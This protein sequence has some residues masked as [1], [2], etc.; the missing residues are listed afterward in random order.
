MS[1]KNKK[2]RKLEDENRQFQ[3]SWEEDYFFIQVKNNAICLLCRDT[4]T[5]KS[6]NLRRHYEKHEELTKLSA[7]ERKAKFE[8]LKANLRSQQNVFHKQNQE[9]TDIVSTSFKISQIIAKKMKPFSD[10]EYIKECLIAAA[11]EICPDKV[12]S[13]KQISLSHQTVARRIDDISSEISLNLDMNTK[14]FV[15]F[16]L[17]LDETTDIKDTSQ[18]AIFIR[19][20]DNQMNITEELL[21]LV[22]LKDTTTGQDIKDAVLKCMEYRKLDLKKLIGITTDGAPSMIGKNEGAITLIRNHIESLGENSKFLDLFICHCFLHIENLCAQTLNMTHVMPVVINVINT[23]K[24]N[25]LKHR[26]F[27][28][29]IQELESEYCDLI[30][31]AK[32]RWLS[33]GKCLTRFWNLREEIRIFM[34]ENG[35]DVPQLYDEKWLLDLCFLIDITTK[36]NE[37]NQK[38]QGENKLI[39]NCYQD[40]KTFIATLKFYEHQLKSNNTFHFPHLNDF[41]MKDKRVSDYSNHIKKLLEEFEKRFA[42]LE[43]LEEIFNIF[44]CPFD[45]DVSSAPENLQLELIELQSNT[46]IKYKFESTELID[47]YKKYITDD[48]FANLKRIALSIVAANGT[49]Y[50]CES[51]FSKLKLVKSKNRNRLTD[52]NLT[53]QLRCAS[54]K[55]PINITKLANSIQKQVSH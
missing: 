28:E 46:E 4:I 6:I 39:V 53:N 22:S 11:E 36:L 50:L 2:K 9:L 38:L 41:K 42:Y 16:S 34:N 5:A 37:L 20:V 32:I 15:Y 43:K 10:G 24:N 21:D 47:F 26:Q 52:A 31:Y 51:F 48:K 14:Q 8:L 3:K 23:I 27:Q 19:G 25:S 55:L 13:Y 17:A 1:D 7:G 33:R 40:I 49:T 35:E 30:Y 12:N 18:F 45:V 54:T 29:Y 44:T